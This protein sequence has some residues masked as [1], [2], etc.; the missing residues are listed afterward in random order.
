MLATIGGR[1]QG[2]LLQEWHGAAWAGRPAWA[3]LKG[4]AGENESTVCPQGNKCLS[5]SVARAEC[6][7]SPEGPL[8]QAP[9][10]RRRPRR[11]RAIRFGARYARDRLL[12][13]RRHAASKVQAAVLYTPFRL[14]RL[15]GTTEECPGMARTFAGR[16]YTA[17]LPGSPERVSLP[18][19]NHPLKLR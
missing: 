18:A 9:D 1:E 12:I 17:P 8:N 16:G 2:S 13:T 5:E 4:S 3:A 6:E 19:L 15:S 10:P 14:L 7:G 11:L